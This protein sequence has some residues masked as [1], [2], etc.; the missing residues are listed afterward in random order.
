MTNSGLYRSESEHDAFGVGFIAH[1]K[2]H[3]SHSIVNQGLEVL[4]NLT[5]RGAV[6]ADPLHGDGAGILI[7]IQNQIFR[8]DMMNQ[9]VKLPPEVNMVLVWFSYLV[10]KL[11][12]TPV[13]KRSKELLLQK[14]KSS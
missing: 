7:Q 8:D 5:H 9:G 14:D 3:K 11:Q 6:G 1:I 4:K 13:M 12:D 10:R 2:G